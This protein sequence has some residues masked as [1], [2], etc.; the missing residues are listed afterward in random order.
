[1]HDALLDTMA[2]R[3]AAAHEQGAE[4]P[5]IIPTEMPP[6]TGPRPCPECDAPAGAPCASWCPATKNGA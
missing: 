1:M 4:Q 6:A 3:Q 5:G 2:A